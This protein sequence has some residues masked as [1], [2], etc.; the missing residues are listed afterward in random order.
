MK[1]LHVVTLHS[2]DNAFGGPVRVALNLSK[3]LKAQG[4]SV[5]LL[6]GSRGLPPTES[7]GGVP[8]K[9]FPVHSLNAI[10]GFSGLFSW[11]LWVWAWQ[12]VKRFDV[13]HLHLARDLVT[14]P[15]GL[16]ALIRRVP[17]VVQGHG[18]IDPTSKY[19]GFLLDVVATRRILRN[20]R[21]ILFLTPNEEAALKVVSLNRHASMSFLPNGVPE[22]EVNRNENPKY[23]SFISRLHEQKHPELF[24]KMAAI[25]GNE[26]NDFE[27][28][29]AGPNEGMLKETLEEIRVSELG[30]RIHYLGSLDHADVMKL[31]SQTRT[32]ILP[33]VNEQFGM[34]ILEALSM[35]VPVVITESCGLVPYI[36]KSGAGVVTDGSPEQLAKAVQF[37]SADFKTYSDNAKKLSKN[38]FSLPNVVERLIVVYGFAI[39]N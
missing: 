8:C 39:A 26:N 20:A 18:M 36:S 4:N 1:I 30:S 21:H 38:E 2:A 10:L 15:V 9:L 17:Y 35:G 25:L 16:I 12:N 5:V 11:R 14:L 22:S 27:F 23:I 13:I 33:S 34:I 28:R 19:L 24:V 32:L 3:E 7:V 6:A 31:L 37:I 29:I